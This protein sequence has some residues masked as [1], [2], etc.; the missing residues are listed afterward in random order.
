MRR[1]DDGFATAHSQIVW[2]IEKARSLHQKREDGDHQHEAEDG[3]RDSAGLQKTGFSSARC[4]F[5]SA[6][7]ANSE[8]G[9]W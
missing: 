2:E 5:T 1:H 8:S 7:S 4:C 3:P 9:V 6:S